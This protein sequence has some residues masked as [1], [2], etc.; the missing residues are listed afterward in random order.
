MGLGGSQLAAALAPEL[1]R[2]GLGYAG[3]RILMIVAVLVEL[4]G[5]RWRPAHREAGRRGGGRS[6]TTRCNGHIGKV[7]GLRAGSSLVW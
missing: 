6:H 1:R 2:E 5:Q 3:N 4:T 7:R